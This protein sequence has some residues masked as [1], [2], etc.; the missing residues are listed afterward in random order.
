MAAHRG[1]VPRE[2]RVR[3]R[4]V[5]WT[6]KKVPMQLNGRPA[7]STDPET[8]TSYA[9]VRSHTR[10]GFVLGEGIGCIDLDHCVT[11]GRIDPKVE[12]F[13]INTYIEIS[14]SGTGLHVFGLLPEG[15]G[16]RRIG[17]EVYSVGRYMTVTGKRVSKTSRL[18]D[19]SPLL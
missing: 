4:W 2:M 6:P 18:A 1:S 9:R 10:K 19:L 16:S 7:S 8:W 12:R 14:P 13:L 17:V 5:L 3:D 15:P 11:D